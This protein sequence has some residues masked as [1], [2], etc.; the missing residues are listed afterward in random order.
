[1]DVIEKMSKLPACAGKI[2]A[3]KADEPGESFINN[4]QS[5]ARMIVEEYFVHSISLYNL[6]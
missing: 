1:M 4:P 5:A 3:I 6:F 2:K